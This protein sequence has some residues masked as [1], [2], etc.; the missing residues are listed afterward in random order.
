MSI[1]G[2]ITTY[3]FVEFDNNDT[4]M[5]VRDMD[6]GDEGLGKSIYLYCTP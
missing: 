5:I 1:D 4:W 3:I 6:V 2:M